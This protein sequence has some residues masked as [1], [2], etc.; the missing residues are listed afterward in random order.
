MQWSSVN[1]ELKDSSRERR[2]VDGIQACVGIE[3]RQVLHFLP[4]LFCTYTK[5]TALKF[6]FFSLLP[7][8]PLP[9]LFLSFCLLS[10]LSELL[11]SL[12]QISGLLRSLPV[13]M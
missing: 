12:I 11:H 5:P 7:L 1:I 13:M 10:F 3:S 2:I 8:L 4:L 6:F 9:P